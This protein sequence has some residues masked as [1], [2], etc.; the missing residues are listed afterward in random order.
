MKVL[1]VFFL[2]MNYLGLTAQN[3]SNTE[4]I[5]IK[6]E[7]K[8]GSRI[9]DR[10]G[11]E[12]QSLKLFFKEKTVLI[13]EN[14]HYLFEKKYSVKNNILNITNWAEYQIDSLSD[15][16][17]IL[18]EIS[19]L[20]L[21]DDRINSFVFINNRFIVEYLIQ[22]KELIIIGDTILQCKDQLS[23]ICQNGSLY[24]LFNNKF[25]HFN[26]KGFLTGSFTIGI[27]SKI[28]SIQLD[29]NEIFNQKKTDKFI[30]TLSS[31][32]GSWTVPKM[33][34]VTQ[35]KI[36]FTCKFYHE[37]QDLDTWISL[38]LY[39]KDT[40]LFNSSLSINQIVVSEIDFN[41]GMNF[42]KNKQFVKAINEFSKCIDNDSTYLDAYYNKAYAYSQ[43]DSSN[44][45]C[46][47]WKRL[48]EM[49][50]KQGEIL[51]IEN[52]K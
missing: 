31:T 35:F 11:L 14:E 22:K 41:N 19:K 43:L 33:D 44:L 26:I 2:L 32:S 16:V 29:P 20:N 8:D 27:D 39:T 18:T 3:L 49:G 5:K 50:Q 6:A 21:P 34:N 10:Q 46:E 36:D 9:I 7:R 13:A 30:E 12:K 24:D 37:E 25:L 15:L 48:K 17:F 1:I 4:W 51:Y 52:C 47:I 23:P 42:L 45:A 40:S 28:Q 38:L